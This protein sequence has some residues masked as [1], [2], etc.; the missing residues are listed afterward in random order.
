M[1]HPDPVRLQD[2]QA[3]VVDRFRTAI[4]AQEGANDRPLL[5]WRQEIVRRQQIETLV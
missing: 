4:K 3:M 5:A 2:Q 1:V